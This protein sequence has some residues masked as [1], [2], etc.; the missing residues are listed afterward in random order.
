MYHDSLLLSNGIG[1]LLMN[2]PKLFDLRQLL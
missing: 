1:S 2:D